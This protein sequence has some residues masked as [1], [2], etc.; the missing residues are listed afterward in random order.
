MSIP[1][2]RVAL[3]APLALVLM[4]ALVY[5]QAVQENYKTVA[6]LTGTNVAPTFYRTAL[7]GSDSVTYSST[8][9]DPQPVNG[10]PVLVV[11]PRHSAGSA[12][13]QIEVGLYHEAG[14]VYS[15]L[16]VADVQTSTSTTRTDGTGYYPNAPLYFSLGAAKAYDVRVTAV[17]AGTVSLKAWTMGAASKAAE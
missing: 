1:R 16:G 14:N 17:S 4:A 12:T 8:P 9:V 15:F 13:A 5:A 10:D 2:K 6:S 7:S 11:V 3:W